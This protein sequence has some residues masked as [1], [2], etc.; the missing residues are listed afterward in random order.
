MFL[1]REF[2]A[3]FIGTSDVTNEEGI[4]LNPTKT[5]FDPFIFNTAVT[6]SKSLV[7]AVGNPYLMLH[8][9]QEMVM[10]LKLGDRAKCWSELIKQCLVYNTFH[11]SDHTDKSKAERDACRTYLYSKLFGNFKPMIERDKSEKHGDTILKAYQKELE[12]ILEYKKAKF[13]LKY[14]PK[15]D[16]S[17]I[18]NF[19]YDNEDEQSLSED[20][21]LPS[22]E[23]DEDYLE[24]YDC[25]LNFHN[26]REAEATPINPE[27]KIVTIRGSGNR[28]GAFDGDTFEVGVFRDNPDGKCYGRVLKLKARGGDAT[29]ICRVSNFNPIKFYPIDKKNPKFFNL[30]RISQD[31][32]NRRD[33]DALEDELKS[34]D[35]V[36]FDREA[37]ESDSEELKIPPIR[38][39]IP[40]NV[41]KDMLFIVAYI[42]WK[43][44]YESPLG[45]VIGVIPKGYTALSAERLLMIKHSIVHEDER[46][47]LPCGDARRGPDSGNLYDRAFTIDPENAQNLDDAISLVKLQSQEKSSTEIYQ[48]GVHIVNCAKHIQHNEQI[49]TEAKRRGTS[50]YSGRG[51]KVMHMLPITT[52]ENLSLQPNKIRDVLS[53]TANVMFH[54]NDT[55]SIDESV[56]IKQAQ[57]K[58]C[59]RL[60][61]MNAQ[62]IMDGVAVPSLGTAVDGFNSKDSEVQPSLSKT[63]QLL[64]KIAISKR[65]ERLKCDAAHSYDIGEPEELRCWQAHMLIEE[66]MIWANNKVS[67][68]IHNFYPDT[69]L[70]R[71]QPRPNIDTMKALIQR[72][73]QEASMSLALSTF[74]DQQEIFENLV[75]VLTLETL[76]LIKTA[77]SSKQFVQLTSLI[78][79]DC[80]YPQLAA[81]HSQL[82]LNLTRAEYCCTDNN[83]DKSAYHH[84]SLRLD[85]YTHFSSPLRRY[86]DIEV[87][88]MLMEIPE[89]TNSPSNL[90]FQ[91]EEHKKLCSH[92]NKMSR[93]S[94]QFER[95]ISSVKLAVRYGESSEVYNAFITDNSKG[96]LELCFSHLDLKDIQNKEKRIPLKFLGPYANVKEEDLISDF[97]GGSQ[98]GRTFS[99]K[100]KMTSFN[101]LQGAFV[102]NI[103]RVDVYM[104]DNILLSEEHS[105]VIEMFT[106]HSADPDDSSLSVL[107]YGASTS[108][109]VITMPFN[110]WKKA[111]DF[112]KEPTAENMEALQNVLPNLPSVTPMKKMKLDESKLSPL[113]NFKCQ[114]SFKPHDVIRV[115][116]TRSIRE[117]L[118][119]P[120]IQIVELNPLVRICVQHNS[121][122]AKCFSDQNLSKASRKV[123][124][125]INEYVNLWERVLLAEAAENSVKEC[126]QVII[127]D[128]SLEWPPLI[129]PTNCIDEEYYQPKGNTIT[130]TLPK[131][132]LE[133]C[134]E[135]IHFHEGD[136]VCVR[137]GIDPH[138]SV[139]AVFHM[140]IYK[141]KYN[142]NDITKPMK[143]L[144]KFVGDS[145]CRISKKMK[146]NLGR[147]C[148]L[149]LIS[150]STSYQ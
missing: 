47:M 45:I 66:L 105:I 51:G 27:K 68:K 76:S 24:K 5:V 98:E 121:N 9:E 55:I 2:R 52:R 80:Y 73:K 88:R 13:T 103:P 15:Q 65:Q 32:L 64:Y 14:V 100:M 85:N 31:F 124:G 133:N 20:E 106:N 11:F 83:T 119:A 29:F 150:L 60:T 116:M 34:T 108:P 99:W 142:E 134:S 53:V 42:C 104:K 6:R 58:S 145:N 114:T 50:V 111:L 132:Y 43:K 147:Q 30:P 12:N 86:L 7:V 139:R 131:K 126:R 101:A 28:I 148:E 89:V 62:D 128:V 72:H 44:P 10:N 37:V 3:V 127:R 8:I 41:A 56:E 22:D 78:F 144:M 19:E 23:D 109:T 136:L 18:L 143:V 129:I 59:I 149:Q 110:Q 38:Q 17:W 33:K 93:N 48:L 130:L 112:V 35:V 117:A 118:I 67:E 25:I 49:D 84:Y 54:S 75:F 82:R 77:I 123:Y 125:S 115:W 113:I 21:Q 107:N 57:V 36:V 71:R 91:P 87:Q 102:L 138:E 122:P 96:E 39:L 95:N 90:N 135:F 146:G 4:P 79:S 61:Y 63:L 94:K 141:I 137:Y 140:V 81:V 74:I 26:Y 97:T 16:L 120:T 40:H 92:L 46:A 70:L 69:A 1:G